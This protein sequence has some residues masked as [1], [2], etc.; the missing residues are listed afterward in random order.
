MLRRGVP[1]DEE[2]LASL[3]GLEATATPCY[4]RFRD[5]ASAT[6]REASMR[7]AAGIAAMLVA[8]AATAGAIDER[9]GTLGVE[10]RQPSK[11]EGKAFALGAIAGRWRGR[12]VTSV[13]EG[14]PAAKA[15]LREG[16]VLVRVGDND[17]YSQD[18]LDDALR[19]ARAG[20]EVRLVVRRA[21]SHEEESLAAK[22]GA[23]SAAAEGAFVWDFAGP[24]Q[25]DE[26]LVL[27]RAE[28]KRVV[29]GL[30]GAET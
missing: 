26:A 23:A 11:E 10:T 19:A 22:L 28:G 25:I 21:G 7:R 24:A 8:L 27:A 13:E 18:D 5:Q 12:L 16:D 29:V 4:N 17:L 9:S 2:F 6:S 30:S 3:Q 15:G 1:E 14:G 20:Q